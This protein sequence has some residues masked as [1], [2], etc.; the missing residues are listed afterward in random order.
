MEFKI[1]AMKIEEAELCTRIHLDTPLEWNPNRKSSE[2]EFQKY[3]QLIQAKSSD[4]K[5]FFWVAEGQGKIV[6]F[7]W[8]EIKDAKNSPASKYASIISLWVDPAY[9]K[10]GV[11]RALKTKGEEWARV[12]GAA[13]IETGVHHTNTRMLEFNKKSGFIPG[14]IQ[15]I[16]D[17]KSTA[18]TG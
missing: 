3:F 18:H 10:N 12:S 4:P 15:M 7:H 6:G 1:R 2:A 13:Y 11:A 14:N 16:K 17:L 5:Y 8:M 9:R